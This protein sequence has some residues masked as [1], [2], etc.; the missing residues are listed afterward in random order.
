MIE[1]WRVENWEKLL[2]WQYA[3][4]NWPDMFHYIRQSSGRPEYRPPTMPF[5]PSLGAIERLLGSS[6]KWKIGQFATPNDVHCN[7]SLRS[8]VV[9]VSTGIHSLC[10]T[11]ELL[12]LRHLCTKAAP[13]GS[14]VKLVWDPAHALTPGSLYFPESHSSDPRVQFGISPPGRPFIMSVFN[15]AVEFLKGMDSLKA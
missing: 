1:L 6:T 9:K 13:P 4:M 10:H 15:S 12:A 3:P 7:T 11:Q 2:V 5:A 14:V 8:I